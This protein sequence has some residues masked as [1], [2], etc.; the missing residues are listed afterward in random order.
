MKKFYLDNISF[1]LHRIAFKKD[2]VI[3]K[4]FGSSSVIPICNTLE[5]SNFLLE[6]GTYELISAYM[7]KFECNYALVN[8]VKH[9]GIFI[10]PGNTVE[11]T[12]GCILTG[13]NDKIGTVSKS[14]VYAKFINSTIRCSDKAVLVVN[15]FIDY[16]NLGKTDMPKKKRCGK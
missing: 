1:I 8:T 16:T 13:I 2:Y 4:L 3:G 15:R 6:E 9:T 5:N 10:H 11:D 14:T 7:P 12:K